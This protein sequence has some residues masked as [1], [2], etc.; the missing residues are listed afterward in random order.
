MPGYGLQEATESA[1]LLP[2]SWV[3]QRMASARNYWV[4]TCRPDGRPHAAPAWGAWVDEAFYFGT[5]AGSVKARNLAVNEAIVVHLESGDEAVILEGVAEVVVQPDQ[6]LWERIATAYAAKYDGFRPDYPAGPH[7][8]MLR[9]RV[10]KAFAW[11]EQDF[12]TS[13]TRWRFPG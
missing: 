8:S 13:A 6:A 2:W 4:V 9:L 12:P 10:Q 11:R 1:D 3:S 5:E 7:S